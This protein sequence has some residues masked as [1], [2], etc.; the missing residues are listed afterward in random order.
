MIIK[1]GLL[2]GPFSSVAN[3]FLVRLIGKCGEFN[4]NISREKQLCIRAELLLH[5]PGDSFMRY[6]A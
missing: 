3:N 1:Y 5:G 6:F 2:M 4:R